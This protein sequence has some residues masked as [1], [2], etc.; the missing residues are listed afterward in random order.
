M[1]HVDRS[2]VPTPKAL[3]GPNSKAEAEKK[4]AEVH[5]AK[6]DPG[7]F[8]GFKAYKDPTVKEALERLFHG[9]C[10]YCECVYAA[11]QPVDIEH[12]RPKSGFIDSDGKLVKP[13]YWWLAAD[14]DNLLPSCIDCNRSRGHKTVDD[15]EENLGKA[16]QFPIADEAK[17]WRKEQDGD[18]EIRLLL[19]PCR[20]QPEELLTFGAKGEVKAK[21]KAGAVGQQVVRASIQVYGLNRNGLATRRRE[22]M[23]AA[24][25]RLSAIERAAKAIK[26]RAADGRA[27]GADNCTELADL[28]RQV[29]RMR[30]VDAPFT[31]LAR[32]CLDDRLLDHLETFVRHH[33]GRELE[34]PSSGMLPKTRERLLQRFVDRFATRKTLGETQRDVAEALGTTA[35]TPRRSVLDLRDPLVTLQRAANAIAESTRRGKAITEAQRTELANGCRQILG[36]GRADER[37]RQ[38]LDAVSTKLGAFVSRHFGD[39]LK[40][41]KGEAPATDQVV[42]RFV[43]RCA[44]TATFDETEREL[45]K[46]LDP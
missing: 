5:F 11:N 34:D 9:K 41:P 27:P 45:L 29:L 25:S 36:L 21:P 12:Y 22:A 39:A 24:Q 44:S 28:V 43:E 32:Q 33:F 23:L 7:S 26:T 4:K 3:D 40:D 6:A 20:D 2:S 1:I 10:A 8:K 13:G 31:A 30:R 17:R 35:K 14:W 46:I 37:V 19:D 38:Q 15:T 18:H 16:N 42:R